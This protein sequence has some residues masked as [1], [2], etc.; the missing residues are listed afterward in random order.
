MAH[1]DIDAQRNNTHDTNHAIHYIEYLLTHH[2]Y[3]GSISHTHTVAT[4]AAKF[5]ERTPLP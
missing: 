3:N 5:L 2:Q 1:V 4:F